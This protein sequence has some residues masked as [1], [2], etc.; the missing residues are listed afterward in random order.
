MPASGSGWRLWRSSTV[1]TAPR[2]IP[3]EPG[4]VWQVG[5]ARPDPVSRAGNS[6]VTR[7]LLLGQDALLG[8]QRGDGANHFS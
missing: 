2:A 4:V 3:R 7:H 1:P 6:S 8:Q 5:A